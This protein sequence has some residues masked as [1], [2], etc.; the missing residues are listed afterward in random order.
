MS[1]RGGRKRI[2]RRW[3]PKP[4]LEAEPK[5]IIE[6]WLTR[7]RLTSEQAAKSHYGLG[8]GCPFT[9]VIISISMRF[10]YEE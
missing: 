2:L 5:G 3:G 7:K 10:M 1:V 8:C 9:P 6:C 4:I